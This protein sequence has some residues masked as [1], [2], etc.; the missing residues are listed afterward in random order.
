[1]KREKSPISGKKMSKLLLEIE[2]EE[3]KKPQSFRKLL[4]YMNQKYSQRR[5][6][7]S[8][9]GTVNAIIRKLANYSY[10]NIW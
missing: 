5:Q 4:E 7:Q 6:N 3:S 8:N 10:L 2:E 1:M 9:S